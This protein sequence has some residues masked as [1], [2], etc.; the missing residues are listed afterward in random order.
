MPE[1]A[2]INWTRLHHQLESVSQSWEWESVW[3]REE[4]ERVLQIRVRIRR[5]AY[6]SQSWR[7]IEVFDPGNN[8]WN[9]LW[10]LPWAAAHCWPIS[11]AMPRHKVDDRLFQKDEEELLALADKLLFGLPKN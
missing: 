5:N 1:I 7:K 9:Y 4:G 6:D 8:C 10:S 2:A 3:R 11:Y